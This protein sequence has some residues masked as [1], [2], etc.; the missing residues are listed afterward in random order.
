MG[1]YKATACYANEF[2]FFTYV[3]SMSPE[4]HSSQL[5][6]AGLLGSQGHL[7]EAI[8]IYGKSC[9]PSPKTGTP[10]TI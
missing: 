2:A 8:K 7:Q 1:V 6:L 9:P 4:G 5:D 10:T 3:T